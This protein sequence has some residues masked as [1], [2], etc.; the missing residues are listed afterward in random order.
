MFTIIAFYCFAFRSP[1]IQL[2]L[3]KRSSLIHHT[4]VIPGLLEWRI[5]LIIPRTLG[6]VRVMREHAKYVY[7]VILYS[8]S[9][10]SLGESNGIR[11]ISQKPRL[12]LDILSRNTIVFILFELGFHF[13]F[14]TIHIYLNNCI[15]N[16][17]FK[18]GFSRNGSGIQR[19]KSL[20]SAQVR[21]PP[22]ID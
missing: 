3:I 4:Q 1:H 11:M 13:C 7:R 9:P 14:E 8:G 2:L 22:N 19:F 15:S 18:C 12:F 20:I 17:T 16:V 21:L 6:R 10:I 5:C